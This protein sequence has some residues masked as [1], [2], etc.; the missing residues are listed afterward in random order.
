MISDRAK[1]IFSEGVS[2]DEEQTIIPLEEGIESFV[3]RLFRASEGAGDPEIRA[4][5]WLGRATGLCQAAR[6]STGA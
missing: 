6:G 4:V 1:D 5:R 3:F 2:E